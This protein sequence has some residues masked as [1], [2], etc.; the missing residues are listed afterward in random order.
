MTW[1]FRLTEAAITTPDNEVYFFGF[2]DVEKEVVKKT[3][4]YQFSDTDGALVQDFGLGIVNLPLT[5]FFSGPTYDLTAAD[6]EKSVS[7]RGVCVLDH[8]VYG[9]KNVVI[10]QFTRR[11]NLRSAANQAVFVITITETIV[12]L[13]PDE[14][15]NTKISIDALQA[16]YIDI[17]AQSFADGFNVNFIDDL[18]SAK[19]RILST[20]DSIKDTFTNLVKTIDEINNSFNE[21]SDFINDNIDFLL[22]APLLLAASVQRLIKAPARVRASAKARMNGY[23]KEYDKLLGAVSKE[24][25]VDAKNQRQEKQLI[26]TATLSAIAE[27]NLHADT[28]GE[29]FLTKNDAILNAQQLAALYEEAQDVL[30]T[31]QEN[32]VSDEL[33]K[34]FTVSD[35]VTQSIKKIMSETSK[36]LVRIS[37]SLNQERILIVDKLDENIISLCYELY[38]TTQNETLDF[39]IN[40]N[41]L[42]GDEIINIPKGREIKYYV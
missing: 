7:L 32:S 4:T 6:F 11:D 9:T 3:S 40:T 12:D 33:E 31:E 27:V 28:D 41:K 18:L 20:I 16:D 37:F 24:N 22:G 15:I 34:R 13:T 19:D 30:D 8:P 29:G 26:L 14:L 5:I 35:S 2:G 10:T 25:T 1:R 36:N 39:F 23:L 42:T 38:G 17:N 21:I